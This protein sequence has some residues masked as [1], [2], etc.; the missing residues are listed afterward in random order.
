MLL[1]SLLISTMFLFRSS[2]SV[3]LCWLQQRYAEHGGGGECKQHGA[4][5]GKW[6]HVGGARGEEGTGEHLR[7]IVELFNEYLSR[8]SWFCF[9]S[10]I[11]ILAQHTDSSWSLSTILLS[12]IT[13]LDWAAFNSV[14][15]KFILACSFVMGGSFCFFLFPLVWLGWA[16][17]VDGGCGGETEVDTGGGSSLRC[18]WGTKLTRACRPVSLSG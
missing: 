15:R 13:I 12:R 1:S 14:S 5:G 16:G 18:V 9:S 3:L 7:G 4:A 10:S 6:E 11:L 17:G 8:I 2:G